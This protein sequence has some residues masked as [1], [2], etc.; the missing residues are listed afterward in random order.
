MVT[1]LEGGLQGTT[2]LDVQR[3]E[4]LALDSPLWTAPQTARCSPHS[5]ASAEGYLDHVVAVF[6]DNL[7]RYIDGSPLRNL[8]DSDAGY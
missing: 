3:Q 5:A 6:A 7:V 4:P 2:I 1:A 8:V